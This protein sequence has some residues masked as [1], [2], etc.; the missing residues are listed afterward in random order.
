MIRG[1]MARLI[2]KTVDE[3]FLDWLDNGD[4]ARD[5]EMVERVAYLLAGMVGS[6]W[7]A[8]RVSGAP[9]APSSRPPR[10]TAGS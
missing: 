5:D 9:A 2:S 7:A 4:P 10:A 8:A 3:A 1:W 6:V